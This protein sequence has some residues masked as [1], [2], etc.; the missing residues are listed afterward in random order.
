ME[1]L[2]FE[3]MGRDFGAEKGSGAWTERERQYL[4][5]LSQAP[6]IGAVTIKKLWDR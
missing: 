1:Q 6:A 3:D 4:Y 2:T 5:W